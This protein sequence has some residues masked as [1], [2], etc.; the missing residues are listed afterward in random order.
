MNNDKPN[1]NDA[2]QKVPVPQVP[3]RKPDDIS[4]LHIEAK[5]KIFDPTTGK[6][7]LEG[8]A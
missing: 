7:F 8:R 3:E 5:V 2:E 1:L 6:V 4:G